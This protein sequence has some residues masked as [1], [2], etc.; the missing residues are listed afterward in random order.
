MTL[1]GHL[2]IIPE[3]T[4]VSISD[5][6]Q[7]EALASLRFISNAIST[8]SNGGL[9][10]VRLLENFVQKSTCEAA[11][12][13]VVAL[14]GSQRNNPPEFLSLLLEREVQAVY[15]A[16]ALRELRCSVVDA[17][18]QPTLKYKG[19]VSNRPLFIAYVGTGAV[20]TSLR[21][22]RYLSTRI[23]SAVTSTKRKAF[24]FNDSVL[25]YENDTIVEKKQHCE[26]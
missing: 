10:N 23:T 1:S 8:A 17:I 22:G 25:I 3:D 19:H 14:M 4:E 16:G 26:R 20:L 7:I 5:K 18:L 13:N 15:T 21:Q 9:L 6:S 12:A 11:R 24:A 2:L